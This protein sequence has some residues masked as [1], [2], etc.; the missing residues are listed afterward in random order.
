MRQ[1]NIVTDAF[2]IFLDGKL[3]AME[4]KTIMP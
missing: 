2:P 4:I 1:F 3:N